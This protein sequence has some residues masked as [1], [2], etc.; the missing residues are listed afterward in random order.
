MSNKAKSL[1][2]VRGLAGLLEKVG[3]LI[4]ARAFETGLH[5]AQWSA[6]RYFA[7]AGP[8]ARTM[9]HLARFQGV[10]TTP[11][12]RTVRTLIAKGL[13]VAVVDS[14]DRRARRLDL[15]KVG[16]FLLESD[17]LLEIERALECLD[18]GQRSALAAGLEHLI[19]EMLRIGIDFEAAGDD[20]GIAEQPTGTQ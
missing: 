3:R 18:G 14:G 11:A 6:L 15:T 20:A 9:T 12:A 7:M 1:P 16:R 5:P 8:Q 4:Q 19:G 2:S 17:P 13:L 10:S